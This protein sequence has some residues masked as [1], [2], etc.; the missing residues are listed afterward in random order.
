[1]SSVRS[2]KIRDIIVTTPSE[3]RIRVN[4]LTFLVAQTQQNQI[5]EFIEYRKK[6]VK[7]YLEFGENLFPLCD[8]L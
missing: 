3:Q 4:L 7:S 2:G 6:A 5:T 1:M 8:V